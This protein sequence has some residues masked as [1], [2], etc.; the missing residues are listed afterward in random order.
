MRGRERERKMEQWRE[1]YG[2]MSVREMEIWGADREEKQ[3]AERREG[4]TSSDEILRKS[5]GKE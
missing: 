4:E 2:D 5:Q 3:R 1:R